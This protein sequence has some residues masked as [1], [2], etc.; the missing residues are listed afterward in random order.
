M[1]A[2]ALPRLEPLVV[3]G[4][5]AHAADGLD[6]RRPGRVGLVGHRHPGHARSAGG[7]RSG[8]P[9]GA[10]VGTGAR[11]P[12][13]I[14]APARGPVD[15]IGPRPARDVVRVAGLRLPPRVAVG[16]LAG[17]AS[18]RRRRLLR[19][20]PLRRG[21][22]GH[23]DGLDPGSDRLRRW[24]GGLPPRGAGAPPARSAGEHRRPA[25]RG[26]RRLRSGF[27]GSLQRHG[28]PGSGRHPPAGQPGPVRPARLPPRGPGGHRLVGVPAPRRRRAAG[29]GRGAPGR[30]GGVE[31]PEGSPPAA[32]GSPLG[33]GHRGD[34]PGA[35]LRRPAPPPVRPRHQPHRPGAG[36]GAAAAERGPLPQP[37]RDVA[38]PALGGGLLGRG[39]PVRAL[40]L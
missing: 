5:T 22:A 14:G 23:G 13:P 15:R 40:A 39:G 3:A 20:S 26:R 7:G 9:P 31:H 37:V 38:R 29:G 33:L 17:G 28:R 19:R 4:L 16:A 8:P 12:G 24:G 6:V 34:V 32:E 36:R 11:R 10:V 1:F 27:R 30:R 21:A 18:H 25:R 35:R 2:G